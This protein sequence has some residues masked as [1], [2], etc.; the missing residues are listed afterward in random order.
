MTDQQKEFLRLHLIEGELYQAIIS[1]MGVTRQE[2]SRW[3]EELRSEREAIASLRVL[4]SRKQRDVTFPVFYDWYIAQK[5]S[6]GYCGIT[7]AEITSLL[8]AGLLTTKRL[9]TR[10][11][12]LELDRRHPDAAYDD[13][14]NLTLA[15][16]WCNNA[17]TDT[18]TAEEF[19]EVGR[20]FAKVWQQR[21][22]QLP[23]A[24]EGL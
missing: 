16:Y 22:A 1:K 4:W 14:E 3:Y 6:C 8:A 24:A 9:A 15:C 13:L 11:R 23:L 19:V 21:L 7:E 17:K 5:R 10:G 20:A 2:L 12:R 18:F